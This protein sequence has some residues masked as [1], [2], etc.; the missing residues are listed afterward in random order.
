MAQARSRILSANAYLQWATLASLTPPYIEQPVI[1]APLMPLPQWNVDSFDMEGLWVYY[2]NSAGESQG[3]LFRA[4]SQEQ[5]LAKEWTMYDKY[6]PPNP[7]PLPADLT[8]ASK[9]LLFQNCFATF[10][11]YYSTCQPMSEGDGFWV[12]PY[13]FVACSK[14]SS[15]RVGR[16]YHRMSWEAQ[17]YAFAPWFSP[18]GMVTG[19]SRDSYQIPCRFGVGWPIRGI[20]YYF[21]KPNANVMQL[22]TPFY[23][24]DRAKQNADHSGVGETRTIRK[25]DWTNGGEYGLAPGV[26]FTGNARDFEGFAP[27]PYWGSGPTPLPLLPA[28]DMRPIPV[29][30][31][32]PNR[33]GFE[34]IAENPPQ[35]R[36]S[37][38]FWEPDEEEWIPG[39]KRALPPEKEIVPNPPPRR[40]IAAQMVATGH[41]P[42]RRAIPPAGSP[43]P[44]TPTTRRPCLATSV[45]ARAPVVR[46]RLLP[47]GRRPDTPMS[48]RPNIAAILAA[49][50]KPSRRIV[51]QLAKLT[52]INPLK[53]TPIA[54]V[55]AQMLGV[56]RV[57]HRRVS[58]P[59]GVPPKPDN[60]HRGPYYSVPAA[61]PP[62][63][64]YVQQNS[65][66]TAFSANLS[67][68]FGSPSTP[69]NTIVASVAFRTGFGTTLST[70]AGWT[71]DSVTNDGSYEHHY[72]H[73]AAAG[74]T[75]ST[76]WT[77]SLAIGYSFAGMME[78]S[79][80]VG[81]Q[82]QSSALG[83]AS[84]NWS[85]GSTAVLS[86]PTEIA[87]V[88]GEC[89]TTGEVFTLATAGYVAV[90]TVNYFFG[91]A[92]L[93]SSASTSAGG[94]TT[95]ANPAFSSIATYF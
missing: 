90:A 48:R 52:A 10:R 81:T 93:S 76:T 70:P 57:P 56:G 60:P 44:A 4:I 23:C 91:Y 32:R 16:P 38:V 87:I 59:P 8:T 49:R 78:F 40:N 63:P 53:R 33:S 83:V 17:D 19:V 62:L 7:P 37:F 20:H 14:A 80:L 86:S 75:E 24:W 41:I 71:A 22:A 29:G 79:G 43:R 95:G 45:I 85:T 64:G 55:L 77:L 2:W 61:P 34:R 94:T 68:T 18:C 84:P 67:L 25:S 65:N 42:Y 69:G 31:R 92:I 30:P 9:K 5:I 36:P 51:Q 6:L 73:K 15:R 3:R 88:D 11:Q 82:D 47:A 12:D 74:T 66:F 50:P 35:R 13:E 1:T 72:F 21:A 27:P 28:C 58:M 39:P 26:M 46:R 89:D 54:A